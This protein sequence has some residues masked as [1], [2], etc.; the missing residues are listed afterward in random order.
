MKEYSKVKT[1]VVIELD[2]SAK[3]WSL[4]HLPRFH[5]M[6]ASKLL[7]LGYQVFSISPNKNYVLQHVSSSASQFTVLEHGEIQQ[8]IYKKSTHSQ[9]E[10][11]NKKFFIK[12]ALG[13]LIPPFL[14]EGL[15]SFFKKLQKNS[16]FHR[17]YCKA[18]FGKYQTYLDYLVTKYNINKNNISIFFPFLDN[19]LSGYINV[20]FLDAL[21]PF[22]WWGLLI[23]TQSFNKKN[24][25]SLNQSLYCKGMGILEEDKLLRFQ[26]EIP[27]KK[28]IAFPDLVI[29]VKPNLDYP[30]VK[31]I[32][33]EAKNRKIIGLFG[34]F[35]E[36]K[37][38][39]NFLY[40]SFLAAETNLHD[41]FFV[42]AG[43]SIFYKRHTLEYLNRSSHEANS[44]IYLSAIK[45]DGDF[46]A[47]LNNC[48]IIYA[49]YLDFPGSSNILSYAA[50]LNKPIIVSDNYL[51][52]KR[53]KVYGI[54]LAIPQNDPVKCLEAI[55]CLLRGVDF[56]GNLL[57]FD[58]NSYTQVHSY[59]N[60]GKAIQSVLN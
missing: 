2:I 21:I 42:L 33:A 34:F 39:L 19:F 38:A 22:N 4:G 54:G 11:K 3:E 56:D 31:H 8:E 25:A 44:L 14:Y 36:R 30:L 9:S 37:G 40:S 29:P 16:F 28:I 52:A 12:Q 50:F 27:Q 5:I 55:D 45:N 48:D 60:L 26:S 24:S 47:V 18:E 35:A 41:Y 49:A 17:R 10:F 51:M 1:I 59:E 43:A 13:I 32:Q 20:N 23:S 46:I 15:N 53:V 57:K 7:E 58:F 6:Y